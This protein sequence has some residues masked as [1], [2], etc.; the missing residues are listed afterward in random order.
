MT[1][2]DDADG[3]I[4]VPPE[5]RDETF[6]LAIDGV[7]VNIDDMTIDGVPVYD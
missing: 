3:L 1:N 7:P 5:N 2:I 4:D 6:E